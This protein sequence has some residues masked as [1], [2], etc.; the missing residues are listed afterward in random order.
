MMVERVSDCRPFEG[1]IVGDSYECGY[2]RENKIGEALGGAR[3]YGT[4]AVTVN[5]RM[6]SSFQPMLFVDTPGDI[7]DPEFLNWVQAV[8]P[9]V[10]ASLLARMSDIGDDDLGQLF[11]DVM[12]ITA[13]FM[14]LPPPERSVLRNE[15]L[16]LSQ[17]WFSQTGL[18]RL[19]PQI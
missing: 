14:A 10:G 16:D 11:G 2:E 5:G 9:E 6:I 1:S 3:R 13:E 4:V 18:M 12:E 15:D 8:H 19:S 7:E 17:I